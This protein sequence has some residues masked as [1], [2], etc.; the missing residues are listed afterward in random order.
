MAAN[1]VLNNSNLF[2]VCKSTISKLGRDVCCS[3][4]RQLTRWS[5]VAGLRDYICSV[6]Y[7]CFRYGGC[8]QYLCVF[9]FDE[10]E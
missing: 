4:T 1:V 9:L 6:R 3:M 5:N 7:I 8:S 10:K 2:A